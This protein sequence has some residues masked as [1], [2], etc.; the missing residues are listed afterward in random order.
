MF[1]LLVCFIKHSTVLYVLSPV[2]PFPGSGMTMKKVAVS[3]DAEETIHCRL[4]R[5]EAVGPSAWALAE[6]HWLCGDLEERQ[7]MQW[8]VKE[9]P[10]LGMNLVCPTSR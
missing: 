10:L 2:E 3:R 5:G 1:H 6:R 4:S 9:M 8:A 7:S